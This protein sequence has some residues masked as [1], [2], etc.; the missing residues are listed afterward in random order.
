FIGS[1]ATTHTSGVI[2]LADRTLTVSGG[3]FNYDA[4]S[5]AGTGTLSFSSA[6]ANFTPDFTNATTTVLVTFSTINVPGTLT[7]AGGCMLALLQ[8]TLNAPLVN[9]RT[10]LVRGDNNSNGPL[11]TAAT[12]LIRV[13]AD[14]TFN[15]F[16]RLPAAQ[17]FTNQGTIE[18]TQSGGSNFG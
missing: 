3:S 11:T 13:Q 16:A 14:D 1:S 10:M 6:T 4:G 8:S 12:S 2:N 5:I 18:I 15:T 17:G 7:N 9:P